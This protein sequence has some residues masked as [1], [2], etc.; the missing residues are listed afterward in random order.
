MKTKVKILSL[1]ISTFMI[2][3]SNSFAGWENRDGSSAQVNSFDRYVDYDNPGTCTNDNC[4]ELDSRIIDGVNTAIDY[5]VKYTDQKYSDMKTYVD[6]SITN[7]KGVE[8]SYVDA[9]DKAAKTYTD[10]KAAAAESNAN[11]YTDSKISDMK[12]YVD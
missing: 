10:G 1:F 3:S 9:G 6:N 5:S 4:S 12:T 11:D 2:F 7:N 8:K